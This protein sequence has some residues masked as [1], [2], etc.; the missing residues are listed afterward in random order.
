LPER[1]CARHGASRKWRVNTSRILERRR[2]QNH[3]C[4]NPMMRRAAVRFALIV[5]FAITPGFAHEQPGATSAHFAIQRRA[6]EGGGDKVAGQRFEIVS[7][8]D[9][10]GGIASVST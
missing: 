9:S 7:S 2:T 4:P 3:N 1:L 6:F 5:S 10:F 8:L